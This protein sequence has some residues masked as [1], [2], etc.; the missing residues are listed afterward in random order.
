MCES[1]GRLPHQ[2]LPPAVHP[3]NFMKNSRIRFICAG[4]LSAW[5]LL[6]APVRAEIRITEIM[7]HPPHAAM[8]P[9]PDAL[10]DPR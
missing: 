2:L 9:E 5:S 7:F 1:H 6:A 3:T 10:P 8:E 4:I